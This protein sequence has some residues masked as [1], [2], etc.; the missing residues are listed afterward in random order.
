MA[1]VISFA[2]LRRL[3][4]NMA[5]QP[6]AGGHGS[7]TEQEADDHQPEEDQRGEASP[8][9]EAPKAS[10]TPATGGGAPESGHDDGHS[11]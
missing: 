4:S 1:A 8:A 2:G 11:H 5:E 9:T 10:S 7:G 3:A 6:G